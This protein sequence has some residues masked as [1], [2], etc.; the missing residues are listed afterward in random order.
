MFVQ[1]HDP[2]QEQIDQVARMNRSLMESPCIVPNWRWKQARIYQEQYIRNNAFVIPESENDSI[3][4]DLYSFLCFGSSG[5][6]E[7]DRHIRYALSVV[8]FNEDFSSEARIKAYLVSDTSCEEVARRM[9]CHQE[10]IR[11][12]ESIFFDVRRNYFSQD[13]KSSVV[14]SG[15]TKQSASLSESERNER[16]WFNSAYYI[17]DVNQIAK[18]MNRQIGSTPEET[19]QNLERVKASTVNTALQ[20]A[21]SRELRNS[22]TADDFDR[23]VSL[24]QAL[25]QDKEN[26][27]SSSGPDFER[28]IAEKIMQALDVSVSIDTSDADLTVS[29]SGPH[30]QVIS[31]HSRPGRKPSFNCRVQKL[32]APTSNSSGRKPMKALEFKI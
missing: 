14:F 16:T 19:L 26:D 10:S 9:G 2:T 28:G 12:Y 1:K 8:E 27:A 6:T 24:G 18:I 3:V 7:K 31:P 29:Q 23:L 5:D 32:S 30:T 25:M 11:M 15:V 13:Y 22:P 20:F 4:L 17:S 21:A